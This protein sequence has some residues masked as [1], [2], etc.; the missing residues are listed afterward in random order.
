VNINGTVSQVVSDTRYQPFGPAAETTYGNGLKRV[1]AQ[2][3]DG[4]TTSLNV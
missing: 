2:D 4:R 3:M 1:V